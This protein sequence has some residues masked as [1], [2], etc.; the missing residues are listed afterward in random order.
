MRTQ[1]T[2]INDI[3]DLATHPLGDE[4][5]R[6]SC[7]EALAKNGV[8]S[9]AGFLKE[10]A[11]AE[12]VTDAAKTAPLAY[13]A[14]GTHNVYLTPRDDSLGADHV[15]NRQVVSS[16]GV[17]GTDQLAPQS[18]LHDLYHSALFQ[19]FICDVVEQEAIYPY[20]DPLSSIN[21]H[22]AG[23]GK[24]LGWHFDNSAFAITLLLQAPEAGGVFEYV[25]DVRDA[26]A[27]D[28]NFEAVEAILDGAA[29]VTSLAIT[30]GTLV[31]FRGRN[32]MH[33][34]TPTIG[35]RDR[36]LVVLAYNEAPHI[37]LSESARMTFFGRLN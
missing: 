9:L 16:K 10:E 11:L 24:E 36:M 2:A 5:F 18:R 30:P 1:E 31:L 29:P 13:Y 4:G 25:K 19:S 22:Y 7:R 6:A 34:V 28:Y 8:L 17:I 33:R 35:K 15:F 14:S 32:A 20:A 12:F 21:V 27:G 37:A 3:I 26:D 23:E